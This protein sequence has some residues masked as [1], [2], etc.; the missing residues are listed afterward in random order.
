VL[1][2]RTKLLTK[3]ERSRSFFSKGS[4]LL[5]LCVLMLIT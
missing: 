3:L 5:D 4:F 1:D 2:A